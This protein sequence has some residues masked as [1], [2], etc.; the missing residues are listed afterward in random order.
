MVAEATSYM[1]CGLMP[2]QEA[3]A[4]TGCCTL[5]CENTF[6]K[7]RGTA[8]LVSCHFLSEVGNLLGCFTYNAPP[9][10]DNMTSGEEFK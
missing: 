5:N 4:Q 9:G 7:I 1:T 6:A 8:Q 10:A 3:Y 2:S